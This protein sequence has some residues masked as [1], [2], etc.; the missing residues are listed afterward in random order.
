VA[1]IWISLLL[2]YRPR[3][4][5]RLSWPSWPTLQQMVYPHKWS[6]ISY[7]TSQAWH[8]ESSPV[9]D[10]HS[11]IKQCS[12]CPSQQI[13]SVLPKKLSYRRGTARCNMSVNSCYVS[14]GMRVR[15]VSISITN[16]QGHS[17]ALAMVPFDRPHTIC[18]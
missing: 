6:P 5:D 1:H 7:R 18:Y 15:K 2:I 11:T 4:D 3:K 17:V 12:Q 14:R 16:L 8:R 9:K 10:W 13:L